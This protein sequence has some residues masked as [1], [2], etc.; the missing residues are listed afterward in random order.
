MIGQMSNLGQYKAVAM[1]G[2]LKLSGFPAWWLWRTY[3]LLRMPTLERKIR[4]AI[5]WTLDL[6]FSRDTVKLTLPRD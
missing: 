5:D 1:L 2:G 6:F 4:V 3:Y